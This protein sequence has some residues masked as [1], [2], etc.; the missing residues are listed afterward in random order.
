ML[1]EVPYKQALQK[2]GKTAALDN[3]SIEI[4]A[5]IANCHQSNLK[6]SFRMGSGAPISPEDKTPQLGT[7]GLDFFTERILLIDYRS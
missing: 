7:L 2:A 6:V 5:T 3:N 4:D 1:Y